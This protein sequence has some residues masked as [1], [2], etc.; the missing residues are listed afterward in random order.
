MAR[1][2]RDPVPGFVDP[3]EGCEDVMAFYKTQDV[4]MEA[5]QKVS[6]ALP[7][8]KF[9][10]FVLRFPRGDGYAV[11]LVTNEKPLTVAWIPWSDAWRVEGALIR[12]LD[13]AD[14]KLQQEQCLF[15]AAEAKKRKA[16]QKV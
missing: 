14:V 11:Y 4:K 1:L 8:G 3:P 5:L 12:G 13:L 2:E 16:K 15:W 9:K 6:D 7:K 10:G